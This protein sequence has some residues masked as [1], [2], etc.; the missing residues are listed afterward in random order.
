MSNLNCVSEVEAPR[1]S[2]GLHR[3]ELDPVPRTRNQLCS[4]PRPQ[5]KKL[6]TC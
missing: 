2:E 1:F 5:N 4:D 6:E 3:K